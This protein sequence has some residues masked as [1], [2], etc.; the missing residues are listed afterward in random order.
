MQEP[1]QLK[2]WIDKTLPRLRAHL[3]AAQQLP[4]S[5]AASAMGNGGAAPAGDIG[6]TPGG[7]ATGTS[8]GNKTGS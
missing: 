6:S 7:A 2:G 4:Q 1:A 3:A 8:T 5:G